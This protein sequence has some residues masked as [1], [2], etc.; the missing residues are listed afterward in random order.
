MSLFEYYLQYFAEL[1]ESMRKTPK[2]LYLTESQPESRAEQLQEQI[3]EIGIPAFVK[4]CADDEGTV[5]PQEEYDNF[6]ADAMLSVLSGLQE[7]ETEQAPSEIRDIYEVFLDSV[8]LDDDLVIYLIDVLKRKDAETFEKLSHAAARTHLEMDDFMAWLG[9]KEWLAPEEE[10]DCVHIMDG[11][12]QRLASEG[13]KE[14]LAALLSGDEATFKRFRVDAPELQHLPQATYEWYGT[15]YL[16]RY[17][18]V[19]FL[20]KFH[21]VEFPQA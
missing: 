12:L 6:D 11:C 9:N 16:D 20:M 1:C 15:N 13:Q 17:Y 7:K 14:L 3:A 10:Q 19:R 18:P 21:G 4:L 5:I 2:G 8:C